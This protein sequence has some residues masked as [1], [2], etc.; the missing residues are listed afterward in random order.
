MSQ[1]QRQ[2]L[3]K[4][5]QDVIARESGGRYGGYYLSS[6][7][8][9]VN[10]LLNYDEE[11]DDRIGALES[12]TDPAKSQ[13]LATS[14]LAYC[15]DEDRV[16]LLRVVSVHKHLPLTIGLNIIDGIRQ[17]GDIDAFMERLESER[18]YQLLYD[19][20]TREGDYYPWFVRHVKDEATFF[21]GYVKHLRSKQLLLPDWMVGS[22]LLLENVDLAFEGLR[23]SR[24]ANLVSM[25]P[26]IAGM[27][28]ARLQTALADD[29][30]LWE[31]FHALAEGFEGT[32]EELLA[33]VKDLNA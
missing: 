17:H 18:A 15:K 8:D 26:E 6:I 13:E 19:L 1:Q 30:V 33:A 9:A 22:S 25:R 31:T 3:I 27:L 14:L 2:D 5:G 20:V 4:A 32:L 21:K 16:K 28:D 10:K 7:Q 23:W 29:Q 11:I 12:E 24:L